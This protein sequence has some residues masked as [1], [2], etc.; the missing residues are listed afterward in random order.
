MAT[1]RRQH[2]TGTELRMLAQ[3]SSQLCQVQETEKKSSLT[4]RTAA[5]G[6]E[7]QCK[8]TISFTCG[9]HLKVRSHSACGEGLCVQG[10]LVLVA[11]EHVR[12]QRAVLD[13][14]ILGSVRHRPSHHHLALRTAHLPQ[15]CCKQGR[16]PTAHLGH[17]EKWHPGNTVVSS[18]AHRRTCLARINVCLTK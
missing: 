12:T 13:P 3:S 6:Y 17:T 7:F 5:T 16:L 14:W 9:E 2:K 11:H 4:T 15:K 1:M 18:I 8:I 10:A